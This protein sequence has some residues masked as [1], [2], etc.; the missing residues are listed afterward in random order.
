MIE[1][2]I[3]MEEIEETINLPDYKVTKDQKIE[4]YKKINN[5]KLKIIYS[6]EG[7]FINIITV[8]D[9]Q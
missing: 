6:V 8:I 1:R 4:V 5:K 7:K 9:K 3:K 2:G